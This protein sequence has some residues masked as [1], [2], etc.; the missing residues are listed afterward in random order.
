MQKV[1]GSSPFSRS[2]E[3]PA[4]RGVFVFRG[5]AG[6]NF[7]PKVVPELHGNLAWQDIEA[8]TSS[9]RADLARPAA[10]LHPR[11]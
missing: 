1:E 2:Y 3:N 7:L 5:G 11:T 9:S 10:C 4:N 6:P 8:R